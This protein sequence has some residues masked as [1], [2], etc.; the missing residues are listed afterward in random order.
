MKKLTL[1]RH[2]KS[3]WDYDVS[4]RDRPLKERGIRDAGRVAERYRSKVVGV[5][6]VISSPAIR[7]LHTAQIFCRTW[8]WGSNRFEIREE[9]YDFAGNRLMDMIR[10]FTP[11]CTHVVLVGHNEALTN[12][13]N[14]LGD[15]HLDN[16][17][18]AGL[19]E[20]VFPSEDWMDLGKGRT[21]EL[22]IPSELR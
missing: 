16:L 3:S 21:S 18:T 12:L 19:A 1:I 17:P 15:Q 13:V 22:I 14:S 4:D 10:R 11:E 8:D 20:L 9:A 2:G 7:A 6:F 5:D